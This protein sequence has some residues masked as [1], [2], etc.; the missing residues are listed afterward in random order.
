MFVKLNHVAS[1]LITTAPSQSSTRH[2]FGLKTGSI[3]KFDFYG[4][5]IEKPGQ[6]VT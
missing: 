3:A 5:G 4:S 6:A 2:S 1:S